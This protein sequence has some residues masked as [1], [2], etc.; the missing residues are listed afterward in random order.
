[1]ANIRQRKGQRYATKTSDVVLI[2]IQPSQLLRGRLIDESNG[3][4]GVAID[5]D[6]PA[7][8][9]KQMIRVRCRAG[10]GKAEVRYIEEKSPTSFRVGLKWDK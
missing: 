3:G 2:E 1:M 6:R 7:L 9:P 10:S 4:I 5:G 8:A